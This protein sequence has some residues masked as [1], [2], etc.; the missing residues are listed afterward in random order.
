MK[1]Y[2]ALFI[3]ACMVCMFV[4]VM[5]FADI[6]FDLKAFDEEFFDIEIDEMDDSGEIRVKDSKAS[7]MWSG[8]NSEDGLVF[9]S[10]DIKIIEQY[11]PCI[12]MSVMLI[13]KKYAFI[14]KRIF[15][16]GDRRYT[17]SA[18][19]DS[20]T[21]DGT[22]YEMSTIVLTDESIALVKDIID[23]DGKI[24]FRLSG[25]KRNVD[26]DLVMP[27]EGLKMLYEAYVASGALKNN[28]SAFRTAFPVTIK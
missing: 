20:E 28:F 19:S 21:E 13:S 26:G 25:S 16:V 4:P 15:K 6:N 3:I 8:D 18:D 5:S 2:L 22:I 27:T 14:D 11:P 10:F 7:F 12:R 23:N 9:G 1:K 17:F 24:K